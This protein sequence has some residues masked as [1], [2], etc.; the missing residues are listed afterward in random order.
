MLTILA[1]L[2]GVFVLSMILL[3]LIQRSTTDGMANLAGSG[4]KSMHTS[5]KV[6]FVKKSTMFFAAAFI[7]NSILMAN[8]GYHM[9]NSKTIDKY[10][11]EQQEN[12]DDE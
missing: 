1:V 2:Q 7:I 4:M 10:I 9:N 11:Q 8:I 3:I 5:M 12:S 6:D